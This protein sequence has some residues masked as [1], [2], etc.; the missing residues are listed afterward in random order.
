[1]SSYRRVSAVAVAALLISGVT[2]PAALAATPD[3]APAATTVAPNPDT[4]LVGAGLSLDLNAALD[5]EAHGIVAAAVG[6][7]VD[8]DG[9]VSLKVGKGSKI[10][11]SKGKVLGGKVVLKG[12]VE[13]SKGA[14]KVVISN[15]VVDIKTGLIT[16]KVGA[17]A[18]VRIGAVANPANVEVQLMEGSTNATLKLGNDGIILNAGV[19]ASLD[20]TLGTCLS[21]NV[22]LDT[23]VT[24]DA[25]LDVDANLAVGSRLDADL[26]VALGLDADIDIDLG[27]Q[28]LLDAVLDIDISLF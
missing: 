7:A 17:K 12:G 24:V 3:K 23:G 8:V 6:G 2:A 14:K 28:G 10:T 1:M 18:N 22:D 11:H 4:P 21:T 9:A 25:A 26:I 27:V 20:A 5:L 16:A 13:L 15:V 19:I